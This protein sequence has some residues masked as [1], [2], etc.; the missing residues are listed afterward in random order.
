LLQPKEV[1]LISGDIHW[2]YAYLVRCHD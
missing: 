1:A 2:W